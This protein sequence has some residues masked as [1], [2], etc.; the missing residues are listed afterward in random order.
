M[1]VFMWALV[2]DHVAIEKEYVAQFLSIA[3]LRHPLLHGATLPSRDET[4]GDYSFSSEEFME[5]RFLYIESKASFFF[6]TSFF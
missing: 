2:S 3:G 6:Q 1:K 4:S 5:A